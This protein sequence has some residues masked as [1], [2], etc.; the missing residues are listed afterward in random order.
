MF[1]FFKKNSLSHEEKVEQAYKCYKPEYVGAIFPNGKKQMDIILRSLSEICNINLEKYDGLGYYKILNIFSD[2]FIRKNITKT[3]RENI[4][5]SLQVKHGDMIKNKDVAEKVL[6][7]YENNSNNPEYK[8]EERITENDIE[9]N[10][11]NYEEIFNKA[12]GEMLSRNF[13]A[14]EALLTKY[15]DY[16]NSIKNNNERWLSFNSNIEFV[17]YIN[18][19]KDKKDINNINNMNYKMNTVYNYL[20]NIEFEYGNYDKAID[21]LNEAIQWNPYDFSANMELAESY[22]AKNDIEKYYSLTLNSIDYIYKE[23]DLARYYR[24]LGYYYIEKQKWELAKAVYLYSLKFENNATAEQELKYIIQNTG[25]DNAPEKEELINILTENKIETYILKDNLAI[26]YNMYSQMEQSNQ[27]NSNLG[28]TIQNLINSYVNLKDY[29]DVEDTEELAEEADKIEEPK[30]EIV[31]EPNISKNEEIQKNDNSPIIYAESVNNNNSLRYRRM[32]SFETDKEVKTYLDDF[33][34]DC[35]DNNLK[36]SVI[37]MTDTDVE[38]FRKSYCENDNNRYLIVYDKEY[39]CGECYFYKVN[40][41][42][43]FNTFIEKSYQN[44][45]N[46]REVIKSIIYAISEFSDPIT[47][48]D[49]FDGSFSI[50]IKLNKKRS[51]YKCLLNALISLEFELDDEKENIWEFNKD[52]EKIIDFLN[53]N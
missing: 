27:L 37:E 1:D 50:K 41:D 10:G 21:Y 39:E 44:K 40:N 42:F 18:K 49:D 9:V 3:A 38:D 15:I 19:N 17:L 16:V 14:A 33:Q 48:E 31:N 45:D 8:Y 34:K 30:Q 53:E 46:Y 23:K 35:N 51:D 20:G 28:E 36:V 12:Q 13:D 32:I 5:T 29:I 2:I 26:I 47:W 43:I 4:L 22:K 7:F 25:D 6:R 11:S 24:N 52:Y